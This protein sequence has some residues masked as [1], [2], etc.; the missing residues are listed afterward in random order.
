MTTHTTTLA[1]PPESGSAR[2]KS[3][4]A[5]RFGMPSAWSAFTIAL[6]FAILTPI[7]IFFARAF[8]DGG[9]AFDRM[10]D[11]PNIGHILWTTVYL[12]V[13]STTLGAVGAVGLAAVVTRVP[14]RLQ[15]T[16][17]VLPLLPLV[18]PPV[19]LI[20]GWIF[21]FAPDVGYG[22]ALL[23]ML[24]LFSQMDEGPI[25]I[26]SVG[27]IIFVT[28]TDVVGIIFIFVYA[29]LRE[30]NGSVEAAARIS[31]ASATRTFFT[32]T[33]PLLRPA[34]VAGLVTSLLVQLG[35]FTAPLFLGRRDNIEVVTTVIFRLREQYPIDYALTAAMGFPLL[36]VGVVAIAAQRRVVGDQRRYVTQGTGRGMFK[37]PSK[38]AGAAIIIYGSIVVVLPIVAITLVAFSPFWNGDLGGITFTTDNIRTAFQGT[39][40]IDSVINT[41]SASALAAIIVLPLGFIAAL[42]MS[43]IVRAPALVQRALDYIFIAPLAVPRALLGMSVLFVFIRP[44]F[45]LYGTLTMFVIG[46]VFIALPFA[47]RSQYSSMIGVHSTVFE[48]ARVCGA[49]QF[50]MVRTIALPVAVRGMAAALAMTFVLL[51]NDFAVSVMVQTPG[52]Q[53]MGTLLFQFEQSGA[54]SQVAVMALVMT[55]ITA[56]V[57]SITVRL[58]GR[59]TLENL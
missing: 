13:G 7:V 46:Y 31:G 23:R 3:D 49:S 57:L 21:L 48:A 51:S 43:G 45:S 20:Y 6:G 54:I 2:A 16:A 22:N 12:A 41:L 40:I 19:A 42:A 11:Q 59:S 33:L 9:S 14:A 58:G 38:A 28:A 56:I 18:I 39:A 35:Q 50:T 5:R 32:V 26:Y 1:K 37:K 15:A 29:R 8:A 4:W 44:P 55:L 34:L 52:R 27:G 30:I 36:I 10:L 47:L 17:A 53:V 25:N 24:P